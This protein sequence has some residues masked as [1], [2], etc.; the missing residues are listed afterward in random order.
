[1]GLDANVW[2]NNWSTF[3]KSKYVIEL[4]LNNNVDFGSLRDYLGWK[5][6]CLNRLE[7]WEFRENQFI[8][9]SHAYVDITKFLFT[10]LG[11]RCIN[12][13]SIWRIMLITIITIF[14]WWWQSNALISIQLHFPCGHL[15][16]A[17]YM[18][19]S[20]ACMK[21]IDFEIWECFQTY[22]FTIEQFIMSKNTGLK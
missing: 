15:G 18:Q 11:F 16:F 19:I 3:N 20:Q 13:G 22:G 14:T 4:G 1:M 10:F 12:D 17:R 6:I 21:G 8:Q 9:N 2:T 5:Y 7:Q